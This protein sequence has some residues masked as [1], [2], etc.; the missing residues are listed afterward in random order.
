MDCK[1]GGLFSAESVYFDGMHSR[2][3]GYK[4]LTLWFHNPVVRKLQR[5]ATMETK[6]EDTVAVAQ[7]FTTLNRLLTDVNGKTTRFNP[8]AIM[9]DEAGANFA[10]LEQIYGEEVK[11]KVF[12]CQFH[13][14]QNA[15]LKAAKL[16][17][18]KQATFISKC[19][20]ICKA[21][22]FK[23][24]EKLR[25]EMLQL[26]DNHEI[27]RWYKWWDL[28]R[29]HIIPAFAGHLFV[30]VNLSEAGQSGMRVDRPLMIVD[31]C[32]DDVSF[33]M[34]Q[35]CSYLKSLAGQ[36]PSAGQGPNQLSVELREVES[37]RLR[38]LQFLENPVTDG[39]FNLDDLEASNFKPAAWERHRPSV[40]GKG[41]PKSAAKTKKVKNTNDG[42][43]RK[44][45]KKNANV[46]NDDS[47]EEIRTTQRRR[48]RITSPISS[49]DESN[50]ETQH[51]PPAPPTPTQIDIDDVIEEETQVQR[52]ENEDPRDEEQPD[53]EEDNA[54]DSTMQRIQQVRLPETDP[55]A[56]PNPV[57]VVLYKKS[58]T[59]CQGCRKNITERSCKKPRNFLFTM[60]GRRR[61]KHPNTGEI[62]T[63]PRAGPIYFHFNVKCVQTYYRCWSE[64]QMRINRELFDELDY[65]Q[66][67]FL[68]EKGFMRYLVQ[69]YY[70]VE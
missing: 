47:D 19:K 66:V 49:D 9:V 8:A 64:D 23:G 28:R 2:V 58:V 11:T 17:D 13:F 68:R 12:G 10:G 65:G 57:M 37:Q 1:K 21:T 27:S 41:R 31:A 55:Y 14:L 63:Q 53:E 56:P 32:Y 24:Y 67:Q 7:F 44:Q 39:Q 48:H 54:F 6:R 20:E 38:V 60:M 42:R 4:S 40:R 3:K 35:D 22:T 45:N 43:K 59:K 62:V 18:E 33:M 51:V 30:K 52:N 70:A 15:T 69:Q 46:F 36:G 61:Y 29:Y 50:D 5:L 34:N 25:D 26:A 16:P